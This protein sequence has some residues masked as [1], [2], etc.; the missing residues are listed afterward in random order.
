MVHR[1]QFDKPIVFFCLKLSRTCELDD[2]VHH[3]GH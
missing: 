2:M 1:L 3:A